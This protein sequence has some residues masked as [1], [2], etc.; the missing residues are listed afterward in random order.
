MKTNRGVDVDDPLFLDLGISW[1]WVVSL[2]P[3]PLYFRWIS[4]RYTLDRSLVES[5]S[6]SDRNREKEILDPTRTRTPIPLSSSPYPNPIPF[7]LLWIIS[8]FEYSN[9]TKISHDKLTS[10]NCNIDIKK[11]YKY[12]GFNFADGFFT[13]VELLPWS[14]SLQ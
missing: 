5:Q 6:R 10:E 3:R 1:R 4:P 12:L 11:V 13:A 7:T 14:L 2:T 8:L 9:E